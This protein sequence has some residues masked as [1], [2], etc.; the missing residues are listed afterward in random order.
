MNF[1]K[2]IS[3]PSTFNFLY[4]QM[5]TVEFVFC[6]PN[7][8]F[9]KSYCFLGRKTLYKPPTLRHQS[10]IERCTTYLQNSG[11]NS[12]RIH[13]SEYSQAL[14][15]HGSFR[16]KYVIATLLFE[17]RKKTQNK[18]RR[19]TMRRPLERGYVSIYVVTETTLKFSNNKK[20]RAPKN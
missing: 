3:A 16:Q 7:H 20:L 19:S 6:L 8:V 10:H 18:S 12:T 1:T 11:L 17:P 13:Q 2:K 15:L 9:S 14:I 5:D 4:Q